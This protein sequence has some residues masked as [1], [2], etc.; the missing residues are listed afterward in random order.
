MM[1]SITKRI[2]HLH[3][4][5]LPR[6]RFPDLHLVGYSVDRSIGVYSPLEIQTSFTWPHTVMIICLDL[7]TE[8]LKDYYN[9]VSIK[10]AETL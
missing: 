3:V 8:W 5:V 1:T 4:A 2:A 7:V 9:N 10:L 6:A